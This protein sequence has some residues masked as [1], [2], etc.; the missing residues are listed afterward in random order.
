MFF[1]YGFWQISLSPESK[2][3]I[4]FSTPYKLY[5]FVTLPFGLFGVPATFQRLMDHML[6]LHTAYVATYLDDIIIHSNSWAEHVQQ[7]ATVLESL[8]QAGLIAN[9][10]R[11]A[12]GQR[13]VRYLGYHLGGGRCVLR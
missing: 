4:A 12:V 8:R 9:L 5:Q 13:E 2:E 7:V 1:T 10:M 11:C 3:K 6:R